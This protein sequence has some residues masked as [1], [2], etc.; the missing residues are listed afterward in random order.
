MQD[1]PAWHRQGLS[2]Y[3]P[4]K[5]REA[6]SNGSWK[7]EYLAVWTKLERRTGIKAP[8]IDR[9]KP[10]ANQQFTP[11]VKQ[12]RPGIRIRLSQRRND[13]T[14]NM[15]FEDN[16][17]VPRQIPDDFKVV[18]CA[19]GSSLPTR[20]LDFA[21]RDCLYNLFKNTRYAIREIPSGRILYQI[22]FKWDVRPL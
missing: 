22:T 14:V 7:C 20:S 1:M 21:Y 8:V 10:I 12:I 15:N 5:Y 11:F 3:T 13:S 4:D 17:G 6:L 16:D 18:H 19:D 9:P 2:G